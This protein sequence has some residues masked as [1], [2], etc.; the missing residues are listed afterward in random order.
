LDFTGDGTPT[1]TTTSTTTASS[2]GVDL[3]YSDVSCSGACSAGLDTYFV[4]SFCN[5]IGVGCTIYQ[6]SGLSVIANFGYYSDGVNCYT[7]LGGIITGISACIIPRVGDVTFIVN[8][9]SPDDSDIVNVQP[10]TPAWYTGVTPSLPTNRTNSPAIGS[11]NPSGAFTRTI[12]VDLSLDTDNNY[13]VNLTTGVY[14]VTINVDRLTNPSQR[15]TFTSV[16]FNQYNNVTI[17]LAAI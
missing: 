14:N 10:G 13:T 16:P 7:F 12:D 2:I 6:D 15:V 8:L 3:G 4:P 9:S 17:T 11:M 5:P 1:T